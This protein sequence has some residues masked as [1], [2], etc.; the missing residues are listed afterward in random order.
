[1]RT[2]YMNYL[3]Y[4]SSLF[5]VN[6]ENITSL[7]ICSNCKRYLNGKDLPKILVSTIFFNTHIPFIAIF[8]ELEERL[9]VPKQVFAQI[10]QVQGYGQFKMH[11]SAINV[12]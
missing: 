1:M 8:F 10:Y 4:I 9:V 2:M 11:G 12:P 3:P 7:M 5:N 6:L